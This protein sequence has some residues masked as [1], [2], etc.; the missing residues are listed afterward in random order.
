[1]IAKN[2]SV[3]NLFY[4]LSVFFL[5]D[6]IM[7]NVFILLLLTVA[8]TQGFYLPGV[9][10]KEF[11]AGDPVV[12]KYDKMDSTKTQLPYSVY[13]LPLCTPADAEK[14]DKD[15]NP[16]T[17]IVNAADNL[18]EVL[19]GDRMESSPYQLNFKE[20][21]ACNILCRKTYDAKEAKK[22][23]Q[24]IENEYKVQFWI[25]NLPGA[26]KFY[27]VLENEKGETV[28]TSNMKDKNKDGDLLYR[29][30]RGYFLGERRQMVMQSSTTSVSRL[31]TTMNQEA[32]VEAVLWASSSNH[33]V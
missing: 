11:E 10:P 29:Y 4:F 19:A 9:A 31:A 33:S 24:F 20:N 23:S 13:D 5:L 17:A 22:L 21:H 3:K 8:C 30:D 18:G 27:Y 14:K 1:M 2:S 28:D 25:D 15:G 6:K 32:T 26:Q 7:R 12:L 16:D